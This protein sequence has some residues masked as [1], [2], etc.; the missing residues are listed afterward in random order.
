LT[1]LDLGLRGPTL[2]VIQ[3]QG[4]FS[5]AQL[6]QM[7]P[8]DLVGMRRVGLTRMMEIRQALQSHGLDLRTDAPAPPVRVWE[9]S[10]RVR[11]SCCDTGDCTLELRTSGTSPAEVGQL[12]T[13]FVAMHRA[14]PRLAGREPVV[15]TVET[16]R[17]GAAS[18]AIRPAP[19]PVAEVDE[20]EPPTPLER[21]QSA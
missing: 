21:P 20:P 17:P 2:G 19:Q 8:E 13:A 3:R 11:L 6:T 18:F 1:L 15:T 12:V 14:C 9:V 16:T 4:V 7:T 5:V 10:R